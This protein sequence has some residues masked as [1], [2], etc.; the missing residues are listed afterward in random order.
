M[1]IMGDEPHRRRV[2]ALASLA[3]LV[4][5]SIGLALEPAGAAREKPRKAHGVA[6]DKAIPQLEPEARRKWP[7][8]FAGLWIGKGDA[9]GKGG[10]KVR[11][12]GL[13][14]TSLSLEAGERV[15]VPL[16]LAD[17]EAAAKLRRLLKRKAYRRGSH[18]AITVRAT[19]AAGNSATRELDIALDRKQGGARTSGRRSEAAAIQL[20]EL[21]PGDPEDCGAD[22]NNVQAATGPGPSY[23]VPADGVLTRWRHRGNP[24][25]GGSGRLQVWRHAGGT[26]YELVGRSALRQFAAGANS[27]PTSIPVREGDLLGL[28]GDAAAGCTF[29]ASAGDVVR[30]DGFGASDPAPGA[31]RDMSSDDPE[32]RVNVSATLEPDERL[33]LNVDAAERQLVDGLRLTLS[34]PE[35]AC[36]AKIS[37]EAV[38][39]RASAKKQVFVAFAEKATKRVGKLRRGFPRP[40]MLRPVSVEHSL[41]DLEQVQAEMIADREAFRDTGAPFP[42]VPDQLYDL[43]IDVT[44]NAPVVILEHPTDQASAAL[45]ERYGPDVLVE[46]RAPLV[47]EVLY[48]CKSPFDCYELRSG[49]ESVRSTSAPKGQGCTTGFTAHIGRSAK[50]GTLGALT[51]AHCGGPTLDNPK[52]DKGSARFH[53]TKRIRYG[54]VTREQFQDRVDAEWHHVDLEPFRSLTPAAEIYVSDAERG[55]LVK[56]VGRWTELIVGSRVCKSGITTGKTCGDVLTKNYSSTKIPGSNRFVIADYCSDP[57]DS[58][59]GV[60]MKI[61]GLKPPPGKPNRYTAVGIHSLGNEDEGLCSSSDSAAFGHIEYA[62]QALDVKLP[63][64]TSP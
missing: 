18:A 54:T 35:E 2:P 15:T 41:R 52:P 4:A 43:D 26:S 9:S 36:E 48:P 7:D 25:D 42:G 62:E 60:Y 29:G 34:C 58:G 47:P 51:A 5:V 11:L 14:P 63:L 56:R 61:P 3:L 23:E 12:F 44:R 10:T 1:D 16:G 6:V 19:D 28:R 32:L 31:T 38:A 46:A 45:R 57:G 55:G 64:A 50:V 8:S 40:G 30:F 39:A 37:G 22:R 27:F 21:A 17:P 20:G 24:P 13:R 33:A 59:A 49:L 53:G